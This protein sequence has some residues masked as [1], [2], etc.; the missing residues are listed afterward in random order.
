MA[1]GQKLKFTFIF[2]ETTPEPSHLDKF[3]LAQWK[4]TDIPTS[5]IFKIILFDE[6]FKYGDGAK[7]CGYVGTNAVPQSSAAFTAPCRA[8]ASLFGFLNLIIHVAGLLLTDETL[9]H[10]VYNSVILCNA[11]PLQ[12]I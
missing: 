5:I 6:A 10:S 3:R 2:I 9:T 7:C 12:T 8:L 1:A 11:I 4:I